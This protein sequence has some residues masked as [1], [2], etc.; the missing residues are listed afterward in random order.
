M[1]TKKPG[2][3][4]PYTDYYSRDPAF[5]QPSPR[6]SFPEGV[7]GDTA[8]EKAFKA[9]SDEVQIARD[10]GDW[11]HLR[12]GASEPTAF[13]MKPLRSEVYAAIKNVA[14]RGNLTADNALGLAFRAGL[15]SVTGLG[16]VTIR[17][18]EYP[19]LGV[20]ADPS[21]WDEAEIPPKL[22]EAV[23]S[24]LGAVLMLKAGF[25]DPKS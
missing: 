3:Q 23:M 20:V 15:I 17:R 14:S 9:W 11:S 4:K 22:A 13:E 19:G 10:Q 25:L 18:G 12:T 1:L 2:V 16:D 24:E 6:S 5:R 7:E 8:H 21:F